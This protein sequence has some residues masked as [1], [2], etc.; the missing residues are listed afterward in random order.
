MRGTRH[1]K[2]RSGGWQRRVLTAV[3]LHDGALAG[4][5]GVG[6]GP[7]EAELH[8]EVAEL[9][10]VVHCAGVLRHVQ[11]GDADGPARARHLRH[12]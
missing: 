2:R 8:G 11:P 6:L 9:G 4:V 1:A 10:G 7:A 5:E 12:I 3:V